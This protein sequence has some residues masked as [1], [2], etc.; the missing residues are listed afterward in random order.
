MPLNMIQQFLYFLMVTALYGSPLIL[1]LLYLSWR[2]RSLKKGLV[3]TGAGLLLGAGLLQSFFH[4]GLMRESASYSAEQSS[5]ADYAGDNSTPSVHTGSYIGTE[6]GGSDGDLEF[7]VYQ[8]AALDGSD[9]W[10]QVVVP[11][12]GIGAVATLRHVSNAGTELEAARLV[13]WSDAISLNPAMAP[14]EFFERHVAGEDAHDYGRHTVMVNFRARRS[15]VVHPGE[16]GADK[17]IWRD[18]INDL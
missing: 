18:G 5:L 2:N 8:F 12:P 7:A 9:R 1:I 13:V 11:P 3:V 17:W 6:P 14:V 4:F 10:L 16:A 15:T